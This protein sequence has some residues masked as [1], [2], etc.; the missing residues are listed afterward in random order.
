MGAQ[1]GNCGNM[2]ENAGTCGASR[3]GP[4][5]SGKKRVAVK[6]L[7]DCGDSLARWKFS[8]VTYVDRVLSCAGLVGDKV[9]G[10]RT[11]DS[12]TSEKKVERSDKF[13]CDTMPLRWGLK[14]NSSMELPLQ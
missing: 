9:G 4:G 13:K 11:R 14:P 8:A 12:R 1:P 3:E 7:Y 2:L 10:A 5:Y 6:A